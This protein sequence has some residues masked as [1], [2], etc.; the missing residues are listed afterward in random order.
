[1][2]INVVGYRVFIASPG[3]LDDI[4]RVFR[5]TLEDYNRHEAIPR[6]LLFVPFG[7]EATLPGVGRPQELINRDIRTCDHAVFIFGDRWGSKP[8]KGKKHTSGCDEE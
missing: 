7:W 4:R 5:D 1:M 2:P 3:G 6:N 8:G